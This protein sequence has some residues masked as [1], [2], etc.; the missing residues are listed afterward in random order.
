MKTIRAGAHAVRPYQE[1]W[2]VGAHCVRP[3]GGQH[4]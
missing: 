2:L 3:A 4:R 1:E